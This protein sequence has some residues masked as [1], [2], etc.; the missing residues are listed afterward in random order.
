MRNR[1]RELR[2]E[3]G[4]SQA[5]LALRLGVARQTINNFETGKNDP[6]LLLAFR[7]SWLLEQPLERLFTVDPDEHA[8]LVGEH[9]EYHD[10]LATAFDEVGILEQM[11]HDGWE[12]TGFGPLVLH[13]R[14]PEDPTLRLRWRY[15]RRAGLLAGRVRRDLEGQ[16]WT[17]CGTWGTLHYFKRTD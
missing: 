16:G 11:G 5:D 13:F 3:R 1:I 10:R 14:R 12:L 6:S 4:W 15:E 9:W 2:T 8:S 7:L 17:Y